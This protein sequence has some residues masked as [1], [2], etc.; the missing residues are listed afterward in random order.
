[1]SKFADLFTKEDYENDFALI[2]AEALTL[3]YRML[4]C[5]PP[6]KIERDGFKNSL[7]ELSQRYRHALK[8]TSSIPIPKKLQ[9]AMDRFSNE[10]IKE[11]EPFLKSFLPA[12]RSGGPADGSQAGKDQDPDTDQ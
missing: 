7:E 12:R 8:N 5:I 11:L 6:E 10:I 4:D 9:P 3:A 1:M 2:T